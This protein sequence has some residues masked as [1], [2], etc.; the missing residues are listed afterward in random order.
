MVIDIQPSFQVCMTD[1]SIRKVHALPSSARHSQHFLLFLQH[2][3]LRCEKANTPQ[4][5]PAHHRVT[6]HPQICS[7]RTQ[8]YCLL[9]NENTELS[10]GRSLHSIQGFNRTM[11]E[12]LRGQNQ[13]KPILSHNTLVGLRLLHAEA[14]S[15]CCR[16]QNS[17]DNCQDIVRTLQHAGTPLSCHPCNPS[18]RDPSLAPV[19]PCKVSEVGERVLM[20]PQVVDNPEDACLIIPSFDTS[21]SCSTCFQGAAVGFDR[22]RESTAAALHAMPNW[23]G[24]RNHVSQGGW[25]STCSRKQLSILCGSSTSLLSITNC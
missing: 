4:S 12:L 11:D 15:I 24:G 6:H 2:T 25:K 23:D 22:W 16:Q 7:K 19:M 9:D 17:P 1:I 21:C 14:R 13:S 10:M 20:S 8:A 5:L 18:K 3:C